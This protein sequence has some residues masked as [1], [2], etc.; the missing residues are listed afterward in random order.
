[1]MKARGQTLTPGDTDAV[2]EQLTALL[3]SIQSDV[4]GS[5]VDGV[6]GSGIIPSDAPLSD[7]LT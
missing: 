1:M 7:V 2:Q 4:Q 6:I 5:A 3:A